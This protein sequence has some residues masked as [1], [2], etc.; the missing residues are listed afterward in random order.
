MAQGK[1]PTKRKTIT[2]AVATLEYLEQLASKGT[3]GSDVTD[4]ARNLVEEGVRSAIKEGF[5]RM[6]TD[7]TGEKAT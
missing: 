5:I 6:R 1:T 3:H 2:F 7:G 4:V